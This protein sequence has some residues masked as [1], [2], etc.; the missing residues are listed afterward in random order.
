MSRGVDGRRCAVVGGTT[1]VD[2]EG[3]VD[4]VLDFVARGEVFELLAQAANVSAVPITVA[5]TS[6]DRRVVAGRDGTVESE[7][8]ARLERADEQ[9]WVSITGSPPGG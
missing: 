1:P 9:P 4:D 5:T 8:R 3:F 7:I 2:V 6:A